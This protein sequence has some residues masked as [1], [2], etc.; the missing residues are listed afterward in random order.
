VST[1]PRIEIPS[2]G[3]VAAYVCRR[4]ASR[5]GAY[6]PGIQ[7]AVFEQ[8]QRAE[9]GA[10]VDAVRRWFDDHARALIELG[11][12]LG[13]RAV[14]EPGSAL[15]PW[16]AAGRGYR[17][18]IVATTTE[19]GQEVLGIAIERGAPDTDGELAI[20]DGASPRRQLAHMSRALALHWSGW[21]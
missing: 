10:T 7:E 14:A 9:Y 15:V 21:A 6:A 13:C 12:R 17:G 3:A 5:A 11:Y 19:R 20:T 18:A 1:G 2:A 8:L 4:I 16:V